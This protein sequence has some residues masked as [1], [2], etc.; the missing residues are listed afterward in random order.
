V[1]LVSAF[2]RAARTKR[3]AAGVS[4]APTLA[5]RLVRGSSWAFLGRTLALPA[6]M[7]QAIVLARLLTPTELGTYFLA[8]SL[9]GLA[10][11]IAQIGLGRTMVLLVASAVATDRPQAARHA[12]RVAFVTTCIT[13]ALA[14]L[15]VSDGPG[16]WIA[17]LLED[18]AG[19]QAVLGTVALLLLAL[20]LMDLLAETFRGFH[21]LRWASLFGDQLLHRI[22]LVACLGAVWWSAWTV[23]LERVMLIA[24]GSA[25]VVLLAGF[26][27]LR[28]RLA[29]LP[30]RGAAWPTGTVLR[31]GP[32]FLFVRLNIWLLAGADLWILGM[33]RPAEEVAIY[34]VA[35]RMALIVGTPLVVANAALAPMIAELHSLGQRQRLERL[36]RAA[37]TLSALPSLLAV[38]L[39][40]AAGGPLLALVFTD[41][42]ARGFPV[43]I[44]LAL[45]Q[46]LH[47]CLGSCG[48]SLTM[49]GNQRDVMRISILFGVLTVLGFV[50]VAGPFGMV[51]IGAVAAASITLY[52]AALAWQARRRVGIRSWATASPATVRAYAGEL[53]QALRARR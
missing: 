49:T 31:H 22:T 15:A 26:L 4:A 32:P 41:D 34:G 21:D 51:G 50:A 52:N 53:L 45:G 36:V 3:G 48:I 43:L 13:G 7:L 33:F 25:T 20:A 37:A 39:Y 35:S 46:W 24:L 40:L 18:A 44:L 1:S 23:D 29:G 2:A 38:V 10:A 19:L 14:A 30:R 6:G 42:Y 27:V 28:R 47:V 8:L 5:Q 16:R 9:A 12:I 17:R 11:I